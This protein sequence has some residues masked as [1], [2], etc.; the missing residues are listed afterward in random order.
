[1]SVSNLFISAFG[2]KKMGLD[3]S[4]RCEPK[5]YT[6]NKAINIG[7]M[8]EHGL[9]KEK[10]QAEWAINSFHLANSMV[11]LRVGSVWG[12]VRPP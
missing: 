6:L 4:V 10:L 12:K 8:M 7:D 5:L 11:G 1:V 9:G 2:L 3:P